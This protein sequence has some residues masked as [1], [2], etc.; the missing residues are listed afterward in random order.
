M[1]RY[2]T[3][4]KGCST[5]LAQAGKSSASNSSQKTSTQKNKE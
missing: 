2:L 3:N 1:D 4:F 5:T